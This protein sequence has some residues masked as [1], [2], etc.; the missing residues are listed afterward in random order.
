MYVFYFIATS[1]EDVKAGV[2]RTAGDESLTD[3][4]AQE[5]RKMESERQKPTE[6]EL[7]RQLE[8]ANRYTY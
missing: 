6:E 8:E 7:L 1:V 3:K 5:D 2:K 4:S